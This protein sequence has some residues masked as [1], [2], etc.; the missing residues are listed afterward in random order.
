MEEKE[1]KGFMLRWMNHYICGW[2]KN[3]QGALPSTALISAK[4]DVEIYNVSY[5]HKSSSA[6]R[7]LLH[8]GAFSLVPQLGSYKPYSTV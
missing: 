2:W 7:S 5:H 8:I 4:A 1:K 6:Y 3:S